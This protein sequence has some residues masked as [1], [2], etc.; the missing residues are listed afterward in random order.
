VRHSLLA[1]RWLT[2]A[3]SASALVLVLLPVVAPSAAAA[4]PVPVPPRI[5]TLALTGDAALPRVPSGGVS[6]AAVTPLVLTAE[7]STAAFS[8]AGVT[9]RHDPG[10][11]GTQV[12]V[13]VRTNGSWSGWQSLGVSDA[14]PDEGTAD[15]RT[16]GR[17]D[18]TEPLWVGPSDGVQVR[19]DAGSGT[20]IDPRLQLVD[21]GSSPYDGT[22]AAGARAGT[23]GV[24]ATEATVG[25]PP[26]VSRAGWGADESLRSY[27]GAGCATPSY[28]DTVKLGFVHHTDGTNSYSPSESAAIVRG[29]YAYHVTG[30]GWCDI[31]YNFLV[32]RYGQV[33]EGRAGG[34]DRPVIG[35]H[36]G[37]F[38]TNTFAASLMGT[39]STAQPPAAMLSALERVFA[40]KLGSYSRNPLAT[41]VL[42]AGTFSGSKFPVGQSVTFNVISGHRD[43]DF[44]DCPGDVTYGLLPQIRTAV[45][46][47]LVGTS[48]VDRHY[49]A[50]GG[51]GSFLGTAVTGEMLTPDGVGR[52]VHYAGGSIYW[53][54][55]TG[56]WEVHGAIRDLWSARGWE[57]GTLGYPVTDET[58]TPDGV[59]RFNHFQGGSVYWTPSTQAH[60]T[61]GAIRDLWSARGWETGFLAYPL[62]DE[63][64]TPDGLG[65][66]NHFQGGS[67]YWTPSTG[68]HE[69]HGAIRDLWS[70]RGWETGFLGYPVGDETVTPDGAGRFSDFQGGSVY[71]TAGTSAHEVHGDIGVRWHALGA[72]HGTL[73]YPVGDERAVPGGRQS[74]FQHGFI[75][76]DAATRATTV[77]PAS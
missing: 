68:A 3:V 76:W 27:N 74:D 35:A 45:A 64:T 42:V 17:R 69:V 53:S 20:P 48:E 50:L 4:G 60:E 7:R 25:I 38:N 2:A 67:V 31:G 41:A 6:S 16:S 13:R 21:P 59:G 62:T 5:E 22:A 37:G 32:D 19:V 71:W 57:T 43:A 72:E 40:W 55:A 47:V 52:F 28:G 56:A 30:N 12:A 61:Q 39:F 34:V 70:G 29:I 58:G 75:R 49:A 24:T 36:T 11:T 73:G 26:I 63:L 51:A 77:I 15:A 9:W 54:A 33:F 65:R 10:V 18:G 14:A 8:L 23:A 1:G 46:S 66:Y 44:T